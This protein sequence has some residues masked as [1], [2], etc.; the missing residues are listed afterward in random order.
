ML[1]NVE[2]ALE[3]AE[4]G[5]VL[6]LMEKAHLALRRLGRNTGVKGTLG[7]CLKTSNMLLETGAKGDLCNEVAENLAKLCFVW[8]KVKL[9]MNWD[10]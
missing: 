2:V 3:L 6:R 8:Q 7:R 5:R 9:K 4:D 10:V 1:K